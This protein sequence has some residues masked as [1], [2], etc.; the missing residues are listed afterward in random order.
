MSLMESLAKLHRVDSQLRALRGRLES[1]ETYFKA[2]SRQVENID[3]EREELHSRERQIRAHVANLENEM[4][5]MDDRLE[6]FRSDLNAAV[7]NKQYS[8]VLSELNTVKTARAKVEESI[9]AEMEKIEELQQRFKELEERFAERLKIRDAAQVQL[10]Q[11]KEDVGA[12]LGELEAERAN[13]ADAVPPHEL[14][15]F[16]ELS[17]TFDGEAMA[18]VEEV[19]RRHR[20]YACGE[21][22]MHMP[23]EK[24]VALMG[25]PKELVRCPACGR[26]LYMEEKV[27]GALAPK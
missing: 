11:R 7:T 14:A 25:E 1:A 6:K 22:N 8:A 24:V 3:H 21:C 12:R 16:D 10:E 23:F 4:A 18:A 15:I 26:I 17:E 2:Q 5:A 27:R 19:D 20:S 9:L 13:A